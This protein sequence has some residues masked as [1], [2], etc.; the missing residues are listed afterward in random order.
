[1]NRPRGCEARPSR[2]TAAA[3]A[4]IASTSAA[5]AVLDGCEEE[6]EVQ[7]FARARDHRRAG[8]VEARFGAGADIEPHARL[9]GEALRPQRRR[10]RFEIAQGSEAIDDEFHHFGIAHVGAKHGNWRILVGDAHQRSRR[11]EFYDAIAAEFGIKRMMDFETFIAWGEP[12]GAAGLAATKPFDG[13]AATVGNGVMVALECKDR[14]HVDRVHAL[15]LSLGGKDEGA[16]GP[17]GDTFYAGYF[18]DLDGNKLNAFVM[19]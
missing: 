5:N 18:R 7:V 12:G 9:A 6:H 17:R 13:N 15:A 11:R 19:G 8:D 2:Y 14:A 16:P 1:M 10:L 3:L 4:K